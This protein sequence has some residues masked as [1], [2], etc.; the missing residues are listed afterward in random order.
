MPVGTPNPEVNHHPNPG[1]NPK[2]IP[3]TGTRKS[4]QAALARSLEPWPATGFLLSRGPV[5][6]KECLESPSEASPL[7]G[8][9]KQRVARRRRQLWLLSEGPQ[10][11]EQRE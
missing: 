3:L 6:S 7:T 10:V 8:T 1:R 4:G 2:T 5:K 9:Q 11:N